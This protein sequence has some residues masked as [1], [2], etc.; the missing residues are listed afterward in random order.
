MLI[1]IYITYI[2]PNQHVQLH[3]CSGSRTT[4]NIF[5]WPIYKRSK[6]SSSLLYDM[7]VLLS[8]DVST[9]V[10]KSSICRVTRKAGSVTVSGPTR[11]WPCSI[12]LTAALTVSAIFDM[13]MT[14]ASRR[15]QNAATVSLFSTSLS[16][17][18]VFS[19]PISYNF[20]NS[21]SSMRDRNGS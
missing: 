5:R 21:W 10:T 15:R 9:H 20:D 7:M 11:T 12:N 19:T 3:A 8:F 16:L 17:A 2:T 13:H 1:P 6:S 14:T 18:D 4:E